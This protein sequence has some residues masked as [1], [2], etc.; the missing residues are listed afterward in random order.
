MSTA[1]VPSAAFQPFC[2]LASRSRQANKQLHQ[3]L[4]ADADLSWAFYN[5]RRRRRR[6]FTERRR[7]LVLRAVGITRRHILAGDPHTAI[8]R[9]D[10][11]LRFLPNAVLLHAARTCALLIAERRDFPDL[12]RGYAGQRFCGVR[13]E[14]VVFQ[15]LHQM[16]KLPGVT[17]IT[18]EVESYLD[19]MRPSP[20]ELE[21][22]RLRLRALA[23]TDFGAR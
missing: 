12:L 11:F 2:D 10:F 16:R 14:N 20:G 13:W 4:K 21:R 8:K 22:I 23:D 17:R 18:S 1:E 19:C 9:L 5:L 7:N 6:N 3:L 15:Q